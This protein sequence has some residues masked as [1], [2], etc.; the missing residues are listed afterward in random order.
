MQVLVI[1]GRRV[2]SFFLARE[3]GKGLLLHEG[4]RDKAAAIRLRPRSVILRWETLQGSY[5]ARAESMFPVPP[6]WALETGFPSEA[7]IPELWDTIVLIIRGICTDAVCS[8]LPR[9]GPRKTIS[10]SG[11]CTSP[12]YYTV[13]PD[14]PRHRSKSRP[15]LTSWDF[16]DLGACLRHYTSD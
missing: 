4:F 8:S 2:N 1:R 3:R 13:R 9:Y 15:G 14:R 10:V 5:P 16:R 11:R 12:H 6:A 7:G